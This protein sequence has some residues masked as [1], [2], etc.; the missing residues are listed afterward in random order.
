MP[1]VDTEDPR[2]A[3]LHRLAEAKRRS[4]APL[5]MAD[6][7]IRD[8]EDAGAPPIG[9]ESA[10]TTPQEYEP[11]LEKLGQRTRMGVNVPAAEHQKGYANVLSANPDVGKYFGPAGAE[12]PEDN[13]AFMRSVGDYLKAK[14]LGLLTK[15][16]LRKA[17]EYATKHPHLPSAQE[18]E[19]KNYEESS[20]LAKGA[21][22]LANAAQEAV[23]GSTASH[24]AAPWQEWLSRVVGNN[25][26]ESR[27]RFQRVADPGLL[28]ASAAAGQATGAM[29]TFH[30]LGQQMPQ[31]PV[32]G[33]AAVYASAQALSEGTGAKGIVENTGKNLLFLGGAAGATVILKNMTPFLENMGEEAAGWFGRLQAGG[34]FALAGA[35]QQLAERG[36]SMPTPGELTGEES[37]KAAIQAGVNLVMGFILHNPQMSPKAKGELIDAATKAADA[38]QAEGFKTSE[39]GAAYVPELPKGLKDAATTVGGVI[40]QEMYPRTGKISHEAQTEFASAEQAPEYAKFHAK[41][42]TEAITKDLPEVLRPVYTAVVVQA[43]LDGTRARFMEHAADFRSKA[44]VETDPDAKAALLADAETAENAAKRVNT[45]IGKEGSPFRDRAAL[46]AVEA[47]PD[48]QAALGKQRELSKGYERDFLDA[49]LHDEGTETEP[50]SKF[51][52]HTSLLPMAREGEAPKGV[53]GS[54]PQNVI[55]Y[56]TRLAQPRSG[57]GEYE[58][59]D[60][61]A[62]LR[63]QISANREKASRVRGIRELGKKYGVDLYT[64]EAPE[65]IGGEKAVRLPVGGRGSKAFYVPES[66]AKEAYAAFNAQEKPSGAIKK[67]ANLAT[68]AQLLL[69]LGELV[70]HVKRIGGS[71]LSRPT[72]LSGKEIAGAALG[73]I[74]MIPKAARL[75]F[76]IFRGAPTED[77][78]KVVDSAASRPHFEAEGA[79]GKVAQGGGKIL[80]RADDAMRAYASRGF[81]GIVEATKNSKSPV[82]DTPANRRNYINGAAG[83]YATRSWP[84][85]LRLA[86]GSGLMPYVVPKLLMMG[87]LAKNVTGS[88]GAE[89]ARA[90]QA[91][92]VVSRIAGLFA[93]TYAINYA[94]NG[95]ADPGKDVDPG[96]IVIGKDGDDYVTYDVA[97]LIGLRRQGKWIGLDA[98]GHALRNHKSAD[99]AFGAAFDQIEHEALK[100]VVGPLISTAAIAAT[101]REP[102]TGRQIA[103]VLPPGQQRG[104]RQ[105]L[106]NLKAAGASLN[107]LGEAAL[108]YMTGWGPAQENKYGLAQTLG[109]G[110]AKSDEAVESSEKARLG[111]EYKNFMEAAKREFR[112]KPAEGRTRAWVEEKIG[113]IEDPQQRARARRELLVYAAFLRRDRR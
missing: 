77:M 60:L 5:G 10:F 43:E 25:F 90:R 107:P 112:S 79:I 51:G 36:V 37:T 75:I 30:A 67:V 85:L 110:K 9:D 71:V 69:N 56:K 20:P 23:L 6:L 64:S 61:E 87:N 58:A 98:M 15:G 108:A 8:A 78:A 50:F 40:G 84:L 104:L 94:L 11:V 95:K 102:I 35:G 97:E 92:F 52:F 101:G 53:A 4:E 55:T 46:E 63:N 48:I 12:D 109:V 33:P 74:D 59:A 68:G 82:L 86:K 100:F 49:A 83:N 39:R 18:I 70:G 72:S 42:D 2:V 73:G 66:L 106:E 111:A 45:L 96:E 7:R 3:A 65:E 62:I 91:A 99:E 47:R 89:G 38:A 113:Q 14:E 44:A 54:K 103:P 17:S 76:D 28:A 29:L 1:E 26:T 93:S 34:G 88:V 80:H 13:A 105:K 22:Y 21:G 16:G 41:A 24:Q 32:V 57:A 31:A 27:E 81:D 19:A